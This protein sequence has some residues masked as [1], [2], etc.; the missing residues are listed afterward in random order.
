MGTGGQGGEGGGDVYVE[1]P[2]WKTHPSGQGA[3]GNLQPFCPSQAALPIK[4]PCQA[5]LC[6]HCCCITHL[7]RHTNTQ[8]NY[9]PAKADR[10]FHLGIPSD[11]L[12]CVNCAFRTTAPCSSLE[13]SALTPQGSTGVTVGLHWGHRT[14]RTNIASKFVSSQ[15]S[16][17]RSS[18]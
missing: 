4:G 12:V 9:H 14:V 17:G 8:L 1:S 13:I 11:P 16:C 18:P 15:G 6:Q 10:C 7:L 2:N 5:A 3:L